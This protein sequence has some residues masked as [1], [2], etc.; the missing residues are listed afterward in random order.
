MHIILTHEQADFDAL[1]SL[2]GAHLTYEAAIPVIPRKLNRNVRAF[3]T[4]YGMELPFVDPRDLPPEPIHKVTLVDTQSMIS[5]KGMH[6]DTQVQVIDH[7]PTREELPGNWEITADETG[8]TATLFAEALREQDIHLSTIQATLL[9]LGIYEDTGSLTYTRTTARDLN[10][11]SFLLEG[12][13]SL[14]IAA[15][16]LNHP[17]SIQQQDLYDNLRSDT[18]SHEI[19][20]HT[21]VLACGDAQKMDEELSTVAHKLRD[22]LDPEALFMLV[23]TRGG[24]QMIARS[25]NEDIDVAQI[26]EH[27][28]GGGHERAAAALIRDRDL[29]SVCQELLDSLPNYVSPAITVAQIMSHGPQLLTPDTPVQDAAGRMQ[30]YGYEGYPVVEEDSQG[31][32]K[33]LGLLTRRAVDRAISHKLNLTADSLMDAGQV[34]VD[35]EDSV[36]ELQRLMTETGWG[37]IPVMNP[38]TGQVIGIVTRTDLLKTLTRQ[39]AFPQPKNLANRLETT[40]PPTRLLLLKSIANTAYDQRAALYIVGGFVRD[41]LLD[42]PSLD[43]DLVV[44][45]DAILLAQ[46]LANKYGGRVTSHSRFGTSKWHIGDHRKELLENLGS[47]KTASINRRGN[48]VIETP[49][50]HADLPES[51]DLITARTEFYTYPTA[52]PTVERGSIKLDLHRRDFTINTLALRLDGHHYAELHD[53]WGGLNDLNNGL[54]RVLHSLS[55]VDDPT[56][57]LRAVRFEQRFNFLIEDRTLELI[58][59]AIRLLERV[60]G[61]RIRHELD[62]IL[63]EKQADKMLARLDGLQL[64]KA[65]QTNLKWD[66]WLSERI[67]NLAD[68]SPEPEWSIEVNPKKLRTQLGYIF[69]LL[70][71]S[72]NR[73]RKVIK[74]LKMP[75]KL[76]IDIFSSQDLW[77]DI[78]PLKNMKP[79]EVV[80]RLEGIEPLAIY[81]NYLAIEDQQLREVIWNYVSSWCGVVPQTDGHILQHLGI[82]PGPIYRQILQTLRSAW[83][84]GTI[85][86]LEEEET[87]LEK[88]LPKN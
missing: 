54:V 51:L 60:S 56:R 46:A 77:R 40:L 6:A 58:N 38:E 12:G 26:T 88:L 59:G 72:A 20:G 3:I 79:S 37:Q 24:V 64:L 87:L 9:L 81:A 18:S 67:Q 63:S 36:E 85:G 11:A 25:T 73:T 49:L 71:L 53:Y 10:A 48:G 76:A 14:E 66:D 69:W 33:I 65:I 30:R 13:A 52:L 29:S 1:A 61:D 45:G 83:L 15:D 32:H 4:L 70:R 43:F 35:P 84:D 47:D 82:P 23:T 62:H 21:I 86:S 75:R 78:A 44:E 16:F 57:M 22:L 34:M 19:H 8:A 27:F 2:L 42:R 80:I 39:T 28:G 50:S 7:H 55:F 5:V 41:M 74:R 68:I 31:K 17:L